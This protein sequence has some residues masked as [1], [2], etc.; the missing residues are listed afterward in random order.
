MSNCSRGSIFFP[1][2]CCLRTNIQPQGGSKEQ[3]GGQ[4][5]GGKKFNW[6]IYQFSLQIFCNTP[7]IVPSVSV[8][9]KNWI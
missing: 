2:C 3:L 5:G 6:V 4:T 8:L 7:S 9:N 1:F